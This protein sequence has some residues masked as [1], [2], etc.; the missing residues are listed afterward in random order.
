MFFAATAALV[1]CLLIVLVRAY[2]GP[3][4]YDRILALNAVGTKTVLMIA[5]VGFLAERP[6]FLDIALLYAMINFIGTMAVLKFFRY[7]NFAQAGRT[8]A[9][10]VQAAGEGGGDD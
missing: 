5:L 4:L 7:G 2:L 10:R 3:T 8:H 6:D 9:K 1:V